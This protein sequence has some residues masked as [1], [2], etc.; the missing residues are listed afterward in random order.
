MGIAGHT[1]L[2][3]V[4]AVT[5][6]DGSPYSGNDGLQYVTATLRGPFGGFACGIFS[7]DRTGKIQRTGTI[8]TSRNGLVQGDAPI[9]IKKN[10][11]TGEW[12]LFASG[13][14]DI[15]YSGGATSSRIYFGTSFGDILGYDNVIPVSRCTDVYAY[16]ADV[17]FFNGAYYMVYMTNN[18]AV[19]IKHSASLSDLVAPDCPVSYTIPSNVVQPT[20]EGP[21]W[22]IIGGK[23][24]LLIGSVVDGGA[25]LMYSSS[26][27]YIGQAFG[28]DMVSESDQQAWSNSISH[29]TILQFKSKAENHLIFAGFTSVKITPGIANNSGRFTSPVDSWQYGDLLLF[30][31][32]IPNN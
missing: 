13:F 24:R 9:T 5:Y 29:P 12:L 22:Y 14:G 11:S 28:V 23:L 25:A 32:T 30:E 7:I 26:G 19:N 4:C 20:A 3:D 6:L 15:G 2:A 16:D 8:L 18:F 10:M 27:E 17:I 21:K 31:A 1:G